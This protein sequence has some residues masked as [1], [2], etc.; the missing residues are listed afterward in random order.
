MVIK[1][2]PD[3]HIQLA[4]MEKV[5]EG[6]EMNVNKD[7]PDPDSE[8][9]DEFTDSHVMPVHLLR[10]VQVPRNTVLMTTLDCNR[11][12]IAGRDLLIHHS[13]L[14]PTIA[15]ASVLTR[16]RN[17][18][19]KVNIVNFGDTDVTLSQATKIGT[20]EYLT[21]DSILA[22]PSASN[23][24]ATNVCNMCNSSAKPATERSDRS[25][26]CAT[27][28]DRPYRPLDMRDVKCSSRT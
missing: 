17:H 13:Q 26:A 22:D 15:L 9:L 11:Q 10:E 5:A 24:D 2:L 18:K 27:A 20:A 1:K 23:A 3:S 14:T 19:I 6:P 12:L 8:G 21:R 16:V 4:A 25:E 7:T 28:A